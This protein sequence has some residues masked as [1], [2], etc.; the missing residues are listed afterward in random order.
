ML[1]CMR[2]A[3]SNRRACPPVGIPDRGGCLA[4]PARRNGVHAHRDRDHVARGCQPIWAMATSRAPL[5]GDTPRGSSGSPRRSPGPPLPERAG[6]RR[7]EAPRVDASTPGGSGRG[8]ERPRTGLSHA[9]RAPLGVFGIAFESRW[10]CR[11]NVAPDAKTG[12][13]PR[14][15][16]AMSTR[17]QR[18]WLIMGGMSRPPRDYDLLPTVLTGIAASRLMPLRD[19]LTLLL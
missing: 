11:N 10:G 18:S 2:S 9:Q 15:F 8:R 1:T 7:M 19:E 13:G 16:E 17:R 4:G 14:T 6:P 3:A 5:L 12:Q